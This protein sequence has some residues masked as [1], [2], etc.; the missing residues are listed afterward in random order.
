MQIDLNSDLGE[1][2]G[3]WVMGDDAAMLDVVSSANVACGGHAGDPETMFLTLQRAVQR[4]VVVGAHPGYPDREGFGR[5]PMALSP[6]EITRLV[7]SQV[8]ALQG[9]AALAGTAVRYVKPHGALSNLAAADANVAQAIVTAVKALPG[10]LAILAISGTALEHAGRSA[11]LPVYAEVFADRA[12]LPDGQLVP[13]TR[14]G[15]VLHDADAAAQRLIQ[16]LD[17]GYMPTLDG[18]SV[19]LAVDSVC[20][21]GDT[22][23]AVAMARSIRERLRAAGISVAP[24][25]A[26]HNGYRSATADK[27]RIA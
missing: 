6:G 24:F 22:K 21:H 23:G 25:L 14:A 18:S 1:A 12:Y 26:S 5:R 20:V 16:F 3:P 11:G 13:R 27:G 19:R 10:A 4:G 15:A 2:Y 7:A 9:I 17:T 8:G